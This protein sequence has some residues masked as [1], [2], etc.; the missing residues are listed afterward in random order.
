M[1]QVFLTRKRHF[2]LHIN[3]GILSEAQGRLIWSCLL[4]SAVSGHVVDILSKVWFLIQ[5]LAEIL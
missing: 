5:Q 2:C 3:L 1:R 4:I